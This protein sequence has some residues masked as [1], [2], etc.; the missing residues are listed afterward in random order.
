MDNRALLPLLVVLFVIL[1]WLVQRHHRNVVRYRRYSMWDQCLRLF[2]QPQVLQ[3]DV[4]FPVLKGSYRGRRVA[5]E[6]IADHIAYRK[7][8]QLWLRATIYIKLP[9]DGVF[10]YLVRPENTEFY[11]NVWSLP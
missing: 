10:E 1:T 3:D 7:L 2:E 9:V 8:P 4:N 5:L 6:P 11:S